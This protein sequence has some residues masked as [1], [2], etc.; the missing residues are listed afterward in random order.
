MDVRRHLFMS[1]IWQ[2]AAENV[3]QQKPCAIC[4]VTHTRGS[5]PRRAGSK[6]LVG[7]DGQILSG[8]IG[9]GEMENRVIQLAKD[10][11]A[12]GQPRNCT[13][14]LA[15]IASGDPGV[16]G[17]EVEI[18]IEPLLTKPT[19]L[20]IGAGHVGR[21]LVHLAKWSGFYVVILDDRAE[22]C[23]PEQCPNA[24]RYLPGSILASLETQPLN[25]NTYVALVTR[26]FPID[27]A[28]LPK[29]LGA[30]VAYVGVI[31]SQRRW[32]SAHKALLEQGVSAESL[33]TVHAPIG[34]EIAAETPEEIAISIMAQIIGLRRTRQM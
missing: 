29:L 23:T 21:A 12:D 24:D 32:L 17:G 16:C 7:G 11:I 34:I 13:Y 6:M 9:G 25:A 27:V 22:L 2:I 19:L 8:T 14:K 1:D 15:D 5:V 33:K 18:F 26:G 28:L 31:G 20:V 3:K 30:G 4:T 10:T